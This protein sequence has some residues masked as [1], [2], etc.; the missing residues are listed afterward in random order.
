MCHGNSWLHDL[1]FI[2][3]GL[4]VA[5]KKDS[6]ISLAEMTYGWTLCIPGEFYTPNAGIKN[7]HN[8]VKELRDSMSKLRLI[9]FRNESNKGIFVHPD[10]ETAKRV[11]VR[12]DL[13]LIHI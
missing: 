3:L 12:V 1:P 13:S 10:L 7:E 5:V 6:G 9:P 8:F 11:F 2:L 4:R